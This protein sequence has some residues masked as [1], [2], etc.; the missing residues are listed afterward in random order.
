MLLFVYGFVKGCGFPFGGLF[1][2]FA[3]LVLLF[4]PVPVEAEEGES[5]A[6]QERYDEV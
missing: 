6:E 4:C 1:G 5:C 3:C 2:S